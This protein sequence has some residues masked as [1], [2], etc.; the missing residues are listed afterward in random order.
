MYNSTSTLNLYPTAYGTSYTAYPPMVWN[1]QTAY[2]VWFQSGP[3]QPAQAYSTYWN[4]GAVPMYQPHP[5][6]QQQDAYYYSPHPKMDDMTGATPL[7]SPH[8]PVK[9]PKSEFN[10]WTDTSLRYLG[11]ANEIGE[12]AEKVIAHKFGHKAGAKFNKATWVIASAYSVVDAL[13]TALRTWRNNDEIPSDKRL[14]KSLARG[15]DQGIFQLGASVFIPAYVVR[16]VRNQTTKAITQ[17]NLFTNSPLMRVLA[18]ALAST[19]II[20]FIVHPIDWLVRTAQKIVYMPL[21]PIGK[22][23]GITD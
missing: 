14:L 4:Y 18:P 20:P 11:Y 5:M 12:G 10:M 1:Q 23:L 13:G 19:V 21:K 16:F 2:P 15:T 22:S 17:H 6:M 9:K 8:Q 3:P 7:A